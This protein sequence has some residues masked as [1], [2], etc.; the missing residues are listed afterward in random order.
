MARSSQ[1]LP[2]KLFPGGGREQNVR[3]LDRALSAALKT[4][5]E[6]LGS[7]WKQVAG[8]GV[9]AQGGS[10]IIADRKSGKPL[11]PMVLWNDARAHAHAAL[12]EKRTTP[13][14]WLEFTLRENMPHGLPR[15][16]WLRERFAN[17]FH[18]FN[19][20]VGAGEWIFHRLTGVWRQDSGNAIQIGSY[21]AATKCLDPAALDTIDLELSFFAGLREEH[22]TAPLSGAAAKR[23]G[24]PQG[25]PIAGP[26]IDQEAGYLSAVGASRQPVHCSLGTA[27]VCNYGRPDSNAVDAPLQLVL[28][29]PVEDGQLVVLPLRTGNTAWDWAL[30]TLCSPEHAKALKKAEAIFRARLYPPEGLLALPHLTQR[31]PV[32]H[33]AFGAGAFFGIN[34]GTTA[35][36][37][38]RAI[39]SSMVFE[40]AQALRQP[41]ARGFADTIVI[42]G[43]ASKG[44]Y[45][46]RLV[47]ALFP[48]VPVLRQIEEDLAV[49]RG[50]L[51]AFAPAIAS[52]R[53]TT[54]QPPGK[55][56]CRA[57]NDAADHYA[58]LR[59]RINGL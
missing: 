26:Y 14:F 32:V 17:L 5:R 11:T 25:M 15:L 46:C 52:A 47:A 29:S 12:I 51:Y 4:V 43:G 20:H 1:K 31:N 3:A 2:V 6:Q 34:T 30:A 9:A 16:A 49:A 39:A 7:R 21:N 45:F 44:T 36:D 53:T 57:I 56:D 10:S 19:I 55:T 40:L 37:L 24:L 13:E 27:W 42:G 58:K 38:L 41:L 33:D 48:A 23:L 28:R 59:E 35:A 22:E 54:V 8:I 50:T 18:D